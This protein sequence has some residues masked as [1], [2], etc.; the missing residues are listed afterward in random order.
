MGS[1]FLEHPSP[2]H[3]ST[4]PRTKKDQA[5]S[6][7]SL[8]QFFTICI[9]SSFRWP[10]VSS[11][12]EI[13]WRTSLRMLMAM[14]KRA[15]ISLKSTLAGLYHI[16]QIQS[17][18]SIYALKIKTLQKFSCLILNRQGGVKVEK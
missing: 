7:S 5:A 13:N 11:L 17:S 12:R 18:P 16:E 9:S 15:I 4:Q 3:K 2:N 8:V 10:P 1:I 14:N 6:N